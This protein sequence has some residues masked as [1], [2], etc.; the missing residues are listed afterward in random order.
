M[1]SAR[2][3][4]AGAWVLLAL[5]GCASG[6][7]E[8]TDTAADSSSV[9]RPATVD[10]VTVTPG[11]GRVGDVLTC[12][13]T[14]TDRDGNGLVPTYMWLNATTGASVG[15]GAAWTLTAADTAPGDTL[16]CTAT[17]AGVSGSASATVEDSPPVLDVAVAPERPHVGDVLTCS[18]GATDADEEAVALR[19]TWSGPTGV[20][21]DG[22]TWTVTAEDAHP[23]DTVTCTVTATDASGLTTTGSAATEVA[24]SAPVV[25]SVTIAPTEAFNDSTLSCAGVSADP[26]GETPTVAYT[27]TNDTTGAA[28]GTDAVLTLSAAVAAPFDTV[29]CAFESL[30]AEGAVGTDSTSVVLGNRAPELTVPTLSPAGARTDDTLTADAR[31][32]DPDGDAVS[33]TWTWY[34][35]GVATASGSAATL[36][37]RTSFAKGQSVYVI[38]TPTDGSDDGASVRSD[39]LVIADTPP[40]APTV[41]ILPTAPG[42]GV[43]AL[44]CAVE[45]DATD[46]DGDTLT[47]SYAWE[48]DGA[49]FSDATTTSATGD[50]VPATETVAGQTWTCTVVP[51]DGG[52]VGSAGSDSVV[53]VEP[54]PTPI[55]IA[56][57]VE[58]SMVLLSDGTIWAWGLNTYGQL[59]DGTTTSRHTPV[60]VSGIHDAVAIAVGWYHSTAL[61]ADGT[62]WNW[63]YNNAG[64]LGD[65]T[66]TNESTPIEVSGLTDVVAISDGWE[67]TLALCSDG[68]VWAWGQ[69]NDGQLGDGTTSTRTRPI[70]VSTASTVTALGAGAFHSTVILS[71]GTVWGWGRNMY[72]QLG[73]GAGAD[74]TLPVEITAFAGA[75][76]VAAGL[77]ST[78]A[79]LSDGT[80]WALGYNGYGGLG[81]GTTTSAYS[82]PV[83][84]LDVADAE[85]LSLSE[86]AFAVASDGTLWAW[87]R[88][89]YGQLGDGTTT[90]ASTPEVVGLSGVTLA[91]AGRY[92]H[93]LAVLSDGT[94]W[95]WGHN[96]SGQLGDGTTTN[97]STPVEVSGF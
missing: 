60:E 63:G 4:A 53:V 33:V 86:H 51:D 30:D 28:L 38:G 37:G 46:A 84:V 48:V 91:D 94:V 42:A 59:G 56:A 80:V 97:R 16:T 79:I 65:G 74:E 43:D 12:D 78:E 3:L 47:Y 57:G 64:Q 2:A 14:A 8:P 39:P 21:A 19:Y 31:G 81:D 25:V 10:A 26:D 36:D 90:N 96:N 44:V 22:E 35:D 83:Q 11:T 66:R 20:L 52:T 7:V 77:E 75:L 17:A 93:S 50:T 9:D 61:L 68:T 45:T 88:N 13:A 23:D 72:G 85:S 70:E 41:A 15:E 55:A 5:A 71:D 95:A 54:P 89:N 87:G 67:H 73:G 27:W 40:T 1:S 24:D 49:P 34:V 62:V 29:T 92:E 58:H 6:S 76:S 82:T 32:S 69:N 18:A